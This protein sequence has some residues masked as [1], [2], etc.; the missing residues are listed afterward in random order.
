[1]AIS[2]A[3]I[4][5]PRWYNDVRYS[6]RDHAEFRVLYADSR[7]YLDYFANCPR[8]KTTA[9]T[10]LR[11][12]TQDRFRMLREKVSGSAFSDD[13]KSVDL[14]LQISRGYLA[15]GTENRGSVCDRVSSFAPISKND[16]DSSIKRVED[17]L[18]E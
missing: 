6:D 3:V 4:L 8:P 7:D 2:V 12:A 14:E 15:A 17:F 9:E 16:V 5:G 1:M 13:S 18:L 11:V 10:D